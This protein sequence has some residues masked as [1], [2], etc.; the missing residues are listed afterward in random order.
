M[1][2]SY[3]PF[4]IIKLLSEIFFCIFHI[5]RNI[6]LLRLK[7]IT[8]YINVNNQTLIINYIYFILMWL[9]IF[10]TLPKLSN[11]G[12]NRATL[13]NIKYMNLN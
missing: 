2:P 6:Y 1:A 8:L 3:V 12:S 11:F 7:W 13:G 5:F 9:A 10:Q 4:D